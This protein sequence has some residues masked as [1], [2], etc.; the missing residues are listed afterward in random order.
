MCKGR[1]SKSGSQQ[2]CP[3]KIMLLRDAFSGRACVAFG[4]VKA[5]VN[6]RAGSL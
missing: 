6:V 4:G 1:R 5:D 3:L 2:I